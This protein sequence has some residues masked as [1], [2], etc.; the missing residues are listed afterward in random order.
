M[1]DRSE[2]TTTTPIADAI[3]LLKRVKE[4][5]SKIIVAF[6]GGKDSICTLA[7]AVRVFGQENVQPYHLYWVKGL[8]CE[9]GIIRKVLSRYP[10]LRPLID[11]PTPSVRELLA[12]NYGRSLTPSVIDRV[13]KKSMYTQNTVEKIVRFRSGIR[14]IAGGHRIMDSLHRRGMLHACHGFW[15]DFHRV[16]PLY[17]W[18]YKDVFS[19]LK[20][21]N[22][23]VPDMYGAKANNASGTDI[24]DPSFILHCKK[25][26]P[27]DFRKIKALF[28]FIEDSVFRDC[29]RARLGIANVARIE[30]DV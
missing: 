1:A 16:Y 25:H 18:H 30:T 26:Y 23:P 24:T 4:R 12:N 5:E 14:W 27:E 28:P 13:S 7:L 17:R 6:S 9:M 8:E 29:V 10:K 19:F 15:E 20:H 2:Y 3:S 21:E 11:L 22:L